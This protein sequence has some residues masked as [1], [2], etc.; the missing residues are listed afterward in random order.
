MRKKEITTRLRSLLS[1]LEAIK[2][3]DLQQKVLDVYCDAL[4]LGGWQV[5]ELNII[6]A[7]LLIPDHPVSYL[8]HT[9]A[10]TNSALAVMK[11]MKQVYQDRVAIDSDIIIA[12]GL[13]HDV[14][15]LLEIKRSQKGYERSRSGRLLRHPLSGLALAARHNIPEEICHIIAC[16]SKE[17]E[18]APRTTESVII[19]HCDF[20]NFEPFKNR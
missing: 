9:L 14:G 12:G 19:H 7:S 17:G 13:L 15:K 6:P 16:H 4:E 20:A 1:P 2:D 5:E 10:V 3:L 11:E 8:E 18:G